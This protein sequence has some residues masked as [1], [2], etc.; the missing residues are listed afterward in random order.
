[1]TQIALTYENLPAIRQT[2]TRVRGSRFYMPAYARIAEAVRL[3]L[4]ILP[5][6]FLLAGWISPA[7]LLA[8]AYGYLLLRLFERFV[9]PAIYRKFA[10]HFALS[11]PMWPMNITLDPTGLHIA[12]PSTKSSFSWAALPLP[13][14]RSD[15]LLIRL[16]LE[17]TLPIRTANLPEGMRADDL[18]TLIKQW[19]SQS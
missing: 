10:P 19:R 14:L 17:R 16:E 11:A 8:Y 18:L 2:L 5:V 12:T 6:P 7:H 9:K 1:M 13:E 15:G 4:L 3:L